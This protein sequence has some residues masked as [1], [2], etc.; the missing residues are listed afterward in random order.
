MGVHG[1]CQRKGVG[2]GAGTVDSIPWGLSGISTRLP[3]AM[4]VMLVYVQC[5]AMW[6]EDR[7]SRLSPFLS[8]KLEAKG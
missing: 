8:V 2:P 4:R 5:G 7:K 6:M 1:R 3:R